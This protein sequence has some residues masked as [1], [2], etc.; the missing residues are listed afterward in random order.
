M[1]LESY[2]LG[3]FYARTAENELAGTTGIGAKAMT[4]NG[5]Q[6]E[7][8]SRT[9]NMLPVRLVVG[10]SLQANDLLH[11]ADFIVPFATERKLWLSPS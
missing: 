6:D 8:P 3:N 9:D 5:G 10:K 1:Y 2:V 11:A 4:V 7:S